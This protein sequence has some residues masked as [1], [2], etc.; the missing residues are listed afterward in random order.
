MRQ[1]DLVEADGGDTR[2]LAFEADDV[3]AVSRTPERAEDAAA[4]PGRNVLVAV[5][6][7]NVVVQAELRDDRSG[8]SRILV[9][10]DA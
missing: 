1:N 9:S 10:T 6:Q 4:R 7:T 8:Q 5:E 2:P 3:A